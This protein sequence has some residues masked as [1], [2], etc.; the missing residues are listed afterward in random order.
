MIT[1]SSPLGE[2]NVFGTVKAEY[3]AEIRSGSVS[4]HSLNKELFEVR[5]WQFSL[6]VLKHVWFSCVS[7]VSLL[8]GVQSGQNHLS[9]S[10]K[11]KK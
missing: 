9:A 6:H 5:K 10:E 3:T 4:L 11:I 2:T 7:R 8:S 1:N